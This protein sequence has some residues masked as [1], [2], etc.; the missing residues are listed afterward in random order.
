MQVFVSS[1][2][3]GYEEFRS[4]A[5]QAIEALGHVA[6]LVGQTHSASRDSPRVACLD[7]VAESDAIVLL[8]GYRYGDVLESGKSATHEEWDHALGLNKDIL[9]FVEELACREERQD[10]FLKE[11][12]HWTD[13]RLWA[14]YSK[15]IELLPEV[16]AALTK[17]QADSDDADPDP[18]AKLPQGCRERVEW[19]RDVSPASAQHLVSLLT[20]PPSRTPGILASHAENPPSWLANAGAVAWEV[21]GDF[22]DAYGLAGSDAIRQRAVEAGSTRSA[23]YL[24]EQAVEISERGKGSQA[25]ALLT[26]VP[27]EYPLRAAAGAFVAGDMAAVVAAIEPEGLHQSEDRDLALCSVITLVKAHMHCE[28]YDLATEVLR[29]AN[30]RFPDRAGL[31]LL[32]ANTTVAMVTQ[33]GLE[34]S[35]SQDLFGDVVDLAL[36]SRDRYRRWDGPSHRALAVATDA[37][38]ALDDPQR[39]VDLASGPPDGEATASEAGAP[40]V[41][42]NLAHAFLML[43]RPQDINALS[44]EGVD[45]SEAARILA[46][47]ADVLGDDAALS[48]MWRSLEHAEDEPSRLKALF[49][50]ALMGEADEASFEGVPEAETALFTGV[51][52]FIR[53]DL[54]EAIQILTPYRFES[55]IHAHYLAQA[56]YQT[57]ATGEAVRTLTNASEHLGAL[58]LLESAADMLFEQ[59]HFD[60]AATIATEVLAMGPS[61][62]LQKRMKVL[63]VEIAQQL[64]DWRNM[65]SYAQSLVREFPDDSRGPWMVVYAMHRQGKNRHAWAYLAG[66]KLTPFSEETAQLAV[67]ICGSVEA[68]EQDAGRLLEIADMYPESEQV[69]GSAIVKLLAQGDRTSISNDQLSRLHELTGDFIARYPQSDVFRAYSAEQPEELLEIVVASLRSPPEQYVELI[70]QVRYGR[71]PYGTLLFARPDLPYTDV[72]LS[73]AADWLTAI[74]ADVEQRAR[75]RTTAKMAL[76]G[77][78]AVDTSVVALGISSGLDV[79]QFG[80][81]FN[82]VRV[83][84]ELLIDARWAVSIA[85]TPV[86]AILGYDPVL[87]RP[88]ITEIDE[89]QQSARLQKAESA[90]ETLDTWQ[91]VKSGP[92]RLRSDP[93]EDGFRPWDGAIRAASSVENCALWCDDLALRVLAEAEGV[94]AFG[95]WALYEAL[96]ETS[97]PTWLPSAT[98]LK[99]RLLRARIADVPI[100]LLELTQAIDDSDG[101]DRAVASLLGRPQI[102]HEYLTEALRWYAARLKELAS[103]P[104]RQWVPMFVKD[105][106]RGIGAAIPPSNRLKAIGGILASALFNIGDPAIVPALVAGSRYATNDLDP[107]AELDPLPDAVKILLTSLEAEIG[108]EAARRDLMR[109]FSAADPADR[110]IV[111]SVILGNRWGA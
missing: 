9:V 8:M 107:S 32:Q 83:A 10:S 68:P 22:M 23:L 28:E 93:D 65:E 25:E 45:A 88:I 35:R 42:G 103:G 84:D 71:I 26:Q 24:I 105:S 34:S 13:G 95:T 69:V 89:V 37:L 101:P 31:L 38:L 85:H 49:G 53:G 41:Q 98:E 102:W 20:G 108:A 59:G 3:S 6:V 30:A 73:V 5:Q 7:E 96:A 58:L 75:E 33:V 104:H 15:P 97:T 29:A 2:S 39:V 90:L 109:L 66:H 60:D 61:R 54:P 80:S 47:Q 111:T 76:G 77:D 70:N 14:S 40:G 110:L 57:G 55:P 81:V 92:L 4:A 99:M 52:A 18:A 44:L 43:G 74:P 48:R 106:C 82:T 36:R 21:I 12:G 56:Q 78:V 63:L 27:D 72:L 51:A 79:H 50:L 87:D 64:Q 86:A 19:L 16:V 1:V 46:L 17:L 62:A 67:A 94:P 91:S 100:S 11:V